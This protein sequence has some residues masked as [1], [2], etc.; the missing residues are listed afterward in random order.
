MGRARERGKDDRE[1]QIWLMGWGVG[2]D[3]EYLLHRDI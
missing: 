1:V 2:E 3:V